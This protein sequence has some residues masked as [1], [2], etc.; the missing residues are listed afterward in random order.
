MAQIKTELR[1]WRLLS[2]PLRLEKKLCRIY[3][4]DNN[5]KDSEITNHF[6]DLGRLNYKDSAAINSAIIC[7]SGLYGREEA[8][9][10]AE[11]VEWPLKKASDKLIS[12]LHDQRESSREAAVRLRRALRD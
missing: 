2:R 11:R 10:A 12:D 7:E 8:R 3:S 9:V 5:E 6:T 1:E 4:E